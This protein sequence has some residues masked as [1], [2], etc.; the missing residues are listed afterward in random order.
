MKRILLAIC[1]LTLC[2][3]SHG[4]GNLFG[5]RWTGSR[6][7]SVVEDM[8]TCISS[9]VDTLN[10]VSVVG[11]GV[12]TF[13]PVN[14]AY[15]AYTSLG[16]TKVDVASGSVVDTLM[17]PASVYL[18][19]YEVDYITNKLYGAHWTG[20]REI[21]SSVDL[22]TGTF[23]DIDTL[24]GVLTLAAGE[25]TYD[26]YNGRYFLSTNLGITVI[27]VASGAILDTL[28]LPIRIG[29]IEYDPNTNKLF[30][31]S[32]DGSRESFISIDLVT[33]GYTNIDTL[34]NVRAI[35]QGN[36]TFNPVLNQY[37]IITDT[38]TLAIDPATG[39]MTAVCN[40]ATPP[41]NIEALYNISL[42]SMGA[43]PQSVTVNS[44]SSAQFS[45]AT[46][47][48]G[49]SYQW[50]TYTANGF[51]NISNGGQYSG[52]NTPTLTIIGV[53]A[54]N[55]QQLFRCVV[56]TGTSNTP[57]R[58]ATL[59]VLNPTGITT[60]SAKQGFTIAHQPGD[61]KIIISAD[62]DASGT[63]YRLYDQS[64]RTIIN[65]A[66]VGKAGSVDIS[67]LANGLYMLLIEGE[68][69]QAFKVVR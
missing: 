44:G 47:A 23:A 22:S 53:T 1:A 21:L 30:G 17:V 41:A 27:D 51:A 24:D 61:A 20:T 46:S 13:D 38:G 40:T 45:I 5:M 9:D 54:A 63:R 15:Y 28:N 14:N 49:A 32:W 18:T 56:H 43:Q 19:N 36:S 6:E 4:Q 59:T 52:V 29:G 62:E 26:A 7:L 37:Y 60:Q 39:S 35:A 11:A 66:M 12:S 42:A 16:I 67:E 69:R 65:G 8:S 34:N 57:S 10:G 3:A 25:S 55:N 31:I 2:T 58:I 68:S 48:A 64:G 50:Q 33:K